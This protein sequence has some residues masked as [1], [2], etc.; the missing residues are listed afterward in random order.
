VIGRLSSNLDRGFV[1]D[2][3]PTP[4]ND[5]GEAA[6]SLTAT[7]SRDDKKKQSKSKLQSSD[8]SSLFVDKDWVAEH[9]RQVTLHFTKFSIVLTKST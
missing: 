7:T 4:Q 3:I 5:A 1:F 9:A 2:L 6:C 8:S